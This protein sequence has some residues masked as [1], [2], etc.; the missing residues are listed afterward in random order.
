MFRYSPW[1]LPSTRQKANFV[2]VSW[3]LFLHFY[4][5][6]PLYCFI[7]YV[8][9]WFWA[10]AAAE[11][12]KLSTVTSTQTS[13][14]RGE[15]APHCIAS[16]TDVCHVIRNGKWQYNHRISPQRTNQ[17]HSVFYTDRPA[18]LWT[19]NSPLHFRLTQ[20][21]V[22]EVWTTCSGLKKDDHQANTTQNVIQG[23]TRGTD[24]TSGG[25]SLF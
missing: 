15:V 18:V 10:E 5:Y 25:C 21:S 4:F 24:Q 6:G 1:R 3:V 13:S 7:I 14:K 12:D 20:P 23:V 8:V 19:K 11:C 2:F 22:T 9:N 16:F 17:K